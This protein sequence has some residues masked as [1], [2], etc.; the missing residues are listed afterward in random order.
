MEELRWPEDIDWKD[1]VEGILKQT[2]RILSDILAGTKYS[3]SRNSTIGEKDVDIFVE[4]EEKRI[5][6][7]WPKKRDRRFELTIPKEWYSEKIKSL[8]PEPKSERVNDYYFPYTNYEQLVD[9]FLLIG[10]KKR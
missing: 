7:I 2:A 8:L 4:G 9:V 6:Q 3:V 5:G 10:S 1:D